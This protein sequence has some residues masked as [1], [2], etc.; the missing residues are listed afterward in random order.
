MPETI[1]VVDEM[2]VGIDIERAV[3]RLAHL[4]HLLLLDSALADGGLGRFSF[5]AADPV[6]FWRSGEPDAAILERLR[7]RLADWA[8]PAVDDLPPF[9]GGAAGVF[10]YEFAR[11]LEHLPSPALDEFRVPAVA[12]GWYDVVLAWDHRGDRGWI[13]SQGLPE[14]DPSRRHRRAQERLRWF[15]ELLGDG[16]S[17]LG[18]GDSGGVGWAERSESH[19]EADSGGT[20]FA[21]PTLRLSGLGA[22]GLVSNFTREEYLRAVERAIEYVAA[23]DVFQVNLAQRL[24][25][26]AR[27]APLELYW[28]L[29]RCNA[30]PMAGYFD[31]GAH[32]VVSASPER[33]VRVHEGT[34]ETRPIKGTRRRTGDPDADRQAAD[35]LCRSEKDRAENVMIVDLM[36]NDLTKVCEP[37]SVQ[38]TDVCRLEQYAHVMHLVSTVEGRLR[39]GQTAVDLIRAAFPGGSI[40]GAPKIRAMQIITEL[41]RVARGPYCGS[42]GYL[43][44]DGSMDLS[45][46]IRTITVGGG[47]WQMPVGGGIVADSDPERE[48]DETWHKAEGLLRAAGESAS[49]VAD[50]P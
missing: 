5:L 7:R 27:C 31:M 20:R 45:I 37:A 50:L 47:W 25:M 49:G 8:T 13:I 34:V 39:Q 33:F 30:A 19:H 21:R 42:L 15:R 24:M 9:Q 41:E 36:R 40:T 28:R 3:A 1:P 29:R 32:Q 38:V 12:L 10:S 35:E 22:G 43:G 46:L 2:P 17:G 44:L 14:N 11:A 6:E 4:P 23:G 18:A 48:Y 26:P 16:G